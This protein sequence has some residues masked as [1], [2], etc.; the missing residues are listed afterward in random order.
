M[1]KVALLV[2]ADH[3]IGSAA[4]IE[5]DPAYFHV[6]ISAAF[7]TSNE[8]VYKIHINIWEINAVKTTMSTNPKFKNYRLR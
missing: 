6:V 2:F 1:F 5:A 7:V 4:Y 3:S 8:F